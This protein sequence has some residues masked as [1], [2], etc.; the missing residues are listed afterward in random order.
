MA[1]LL[2]VLGAILLFVAYPSSQGLGDPM[3]GAVT[4]RFADA[5]EWLTVL[6]V[7]S[8]VSGVGYLLP[9]GTTID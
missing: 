2:I 4:G 5:T 3:T 1:F 6:G 9:G 8:S 7:A